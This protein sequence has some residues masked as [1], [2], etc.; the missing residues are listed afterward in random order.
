MSRRGNCWDNAAAESFFATVKVELGPEASWA[1]RGQA[2]GEVPA[3]SEQFYNGQRRHSALGYLSPLTFERRWATEGGT[4]PGAASPALA[5]GASAKARA[6]EALG[7]TRRRGAAISVSPPAPSVTPISSI[8]GI[9]EAAPPTFGR[10]P[11]TGSP[12]PLT[13]VSTEPG[14][15]Q[16]G[17][18]VQHLTTALFLSKPVRPLLAYAPGAPAP[19]DRGLLPAVRLPVRQRPGRHQSQD[20]PRELQRL[21]ETHG[22]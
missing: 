9:L 10:N 8:P 16:P 12:H 22:D 1:T 2:R 4:T 11:S 15:V 5:G 6:V 18:A 20:G 13:A 7:A 14:Q 3:S 21:R 17:I 19:C